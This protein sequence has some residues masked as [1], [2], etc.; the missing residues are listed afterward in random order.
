MKVFFI[1]NFNGHK[2]YLIK[3]N[4]DYSEDNITLVYT[5]HEKE[6]YKSLLVII[7]P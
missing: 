2:Y 3:D 5:K 6:Y 4:L 1:L 7:T